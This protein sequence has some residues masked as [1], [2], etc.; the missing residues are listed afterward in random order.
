MFGNTPCD[1]FNKLQKTDQQRVTDAA[2]RIL[3]QNLQAAK[4]NMSIRNQSND[5]L[6]VEVAV[7]SLRFIYSLLAWATTDFNFS[8]FPRHEMIDL[9]RL[10]LGE[11]VT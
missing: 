11:S 3:N 10:V 5:D 7:E 4:T 9:G 1:A 2:K 6:F 8:Q